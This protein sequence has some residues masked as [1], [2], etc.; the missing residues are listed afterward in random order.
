M[1]LLTLITLS[2][3]AM[4]M[5]ALALDKKADRASA[6]ENFKQ[7]DGNK[8]RKLTKAEF[9]KLIDANAADN[10]GKAPMIKRFG[11][12]D[13]AFARVDTNKDGIITLKELAALRGK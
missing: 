1:R 11:A 4:T 9:R 3:V 7:A 13:T 8:D 5:P 6:Q 10:L 12:Y 2:T